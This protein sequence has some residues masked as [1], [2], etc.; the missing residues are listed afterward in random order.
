[1]RRSHLLA[2]IALV[3]L[4]LVRTPANPN[5][6]K[7]PRLRRRPRVKPKVVVRHNSPNRYPRGI[8]GYQLIVLH[9]TEGQNKFKSIEDLEGL[10]AMFGDRSFEASSQVAVD[11]DGWS[12]RYVGDVDAAWHCASF[13]RVSLGIEEVGFAAGKWNKAERREAARW[14][15]QWS[16]MYGI[17]LRR[18]KIEGET[19]VRT[20]IVR[21]SDLGPAGGGHSDPGPN[22]NVKSVI[23]WARWY[24]FLRYGRVR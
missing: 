2:L 7:R 11:G 17:P 21:H 4:M 10:G 19:V 23:R 5:G 8:T 15:A 3:P 24:K 20:G 1:M 18:G 12:A 6:H 16:H 14:C 13:N 9:S 22:Y